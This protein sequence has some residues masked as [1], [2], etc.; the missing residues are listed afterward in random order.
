MKGRPTQLFADD[1][2]CRAGA[3]FW[4]SPASEHRSTRPNSTLLKWQPSDLALA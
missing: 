1:S 3:L 4:F 2:K